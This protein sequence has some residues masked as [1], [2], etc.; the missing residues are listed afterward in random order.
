MNE[1]EI[2]RLRVHA[3]AVIDQLVE[4]SWR[5]NLS[6]DGVHVALALRPARRTRIWEARA[7]SDDQL[8]MVMEL[9]AIGHAVMCHQKMENTD[10]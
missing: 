8:L 7:L 5:K 1:N 6:G 2:G 9:A 4:S 10:E 3:Q